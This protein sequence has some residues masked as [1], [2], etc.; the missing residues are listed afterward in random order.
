MTTRLSLIAA[1]LLFLTACENKSEQPQ[2]TVEG[3]SAHIVDTTQKKLTE[4]EWAERAK[5]HPKLAEVDNKTG[6]YKFAATN[7]EFNQFGELIALSDYAKR[8]QNED[9]ILLCPSNKEF[10]LKDKNIVE[11]L[12]LPEHKSELNKLI[13]NHIIKPPFN[14]EKLDLVGEVRNIEG[15]VYKVDANKRT[16]ENVDLGTYEV[17]CDVG[18]ISELRGVI[19]FPTSLKPGDRKK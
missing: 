13:A 8:L 14:V 12:K 4:A 7:A 18:K 16:I 3:A 11:L 17:I 10:S 5:K 2:N 1:A 19:G 15:K 9:L 6:P